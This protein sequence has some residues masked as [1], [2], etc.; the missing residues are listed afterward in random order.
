SKWIFGGG[1]KSTGR[2][3]MAT[4]PRTYRIGRRGPTAAIRSR[5]QLPAATTTRPDLRSPAPRTLSPATRPDWVAIDA[6]VQSS[7][8]FAPSTAAA[9]ARFVV[10]SHQ[11]AAVARGAAGDVAFLEQDDVDVAPRQ[12][13]GDACPHAPAAHHDDLGLLR[14]VWRDHRGPGWCLSLS[15]F[16]LY[17]RS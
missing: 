2:R 1:P 9:A 10:L 12:V 17:Y 6:T 3:R 7:N 16:P 8:T 15:P 13:E 11:G 14:E 4:S 5:V